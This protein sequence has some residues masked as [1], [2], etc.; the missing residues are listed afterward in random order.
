M[1]LVGFVIGI[2]HDAQSHEHKIRVEII[3]LQSIL[4]HCTSNPDITSH[5]EFITNCPL[6]NRLNGNSKEDQLNIKPRTF[7]PTSHTPTE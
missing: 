1:H 5:V 4:Q 2:R 7:F 6:C 3:S